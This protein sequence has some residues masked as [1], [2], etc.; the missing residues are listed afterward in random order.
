MQVFRLQIMTNLS[1]IVYTGIKLTVKYQI[2]AHQF[3]PSYIP[4]HSRIPVQL[5]RVR[6]VFRN[7]L[8][9]LM[10]LFKIQ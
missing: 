6:I 4:I 2:Y 10:F 1:L 5:P 3:I 7:H 9:D 8:K